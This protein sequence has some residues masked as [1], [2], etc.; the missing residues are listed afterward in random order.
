MY[1]YLFHLLCFQGY[2][3]SADGLQRKL[4]WRVKPGELGDSQFT[5]N[6]SAAIFGNRV[7]ME[8]SVDGQAHPGNKKLYPALDPELLENLKGLFSRLVKTCNKKEKGKFRKK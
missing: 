6:L 3:E 2:F 7:L 4:L 8:S 5:K 1:P